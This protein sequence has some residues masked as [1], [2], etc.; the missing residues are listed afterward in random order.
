ML[1]LAAYLEKELQRLDLLL[2]REILRLRARYQLTLD[3]FRGLYVG[4]QQ[5]DSL[6]SE[7]VGEATGAEELTRRADELRTLN[8]RDRPGEWTLLESEF[9]LSNGEQDVILLTIAREANLK[10]ETIFAYLHNDVSRKKPTVELALRLFSSISRNSFLPE[11]PLLE[12]G[13]LIAVGQGGFLGRDLEAT[14]PLLR[15][16]LGMSAESSVPLPLCPPEETLIRSV[17]LARLFVVEHQ[18]LA[19][20]RLAVE[21]S[22]HSAGKRLLAIDPSGGDLPALARRIHLLQRLERCGVCLY[23]TAALWS[24]DPSLPEVRR[25][26]EALAAPSGPIWILSSP[27]S[28]WRGSLPGESVRVISLPQFSQDQRQRTWHAELPGADAAMSKTL[29]SRYS[30]SS[31]QIRA[32][33][34]SARDNVSLKKEDRPPEWDELVA[35][36]QSQSESAIG[37][38]AQRLICRHGWNDLVLPAGTLRQVREVAGAIRCHHVVYANWGFGA[39]HT[40]IDGLK[41]LFAGASG[42]G[43]TMTAGVLGNDLGLDVYRIDLS[44]IVSKYIGET[45]KN[46]DRVFQAAEGS[47]S[48]LFFD[49]ADALFG[50]RSEVKDAHDRYA[51]IEVAYLLQKFEEHD[52]PVILATN[53]RRNLDEAFSRRMH[54]VIEFPQPDEEHR[55]ILWQKIFPRQTPTSGIDFDFLAAQFQITG[56]DI[57]NVA[58]DAAFLAAQ[59]GGVVTMRQIA[60]AMSRQ[61]VK[62][63]RPSAPVDFK[64]YHSLVPRQGT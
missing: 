5:V 57:R 43:K 54:Y 4:D 27:G 58:L 41:I 46:L 7:T 11:A 38:H 8:A 42:T 2:H 25:F 35:A 29:A 59:D 32:A 28:A 39:R 1:P 21:S 12:H 52:G 45:E 17:S 55:L 31:H 6:V 49:E 22:C 30:L 50:K 48:I 60:A 36:I 26:F 33:A 9:G 20:A 15:H 63:G 19:A 23:N 61:M 47:N 3:E 14:L 34:Q 37:R 16:L 18:D 56:G 13:L 51:N 53:L 44:R 64:Q 40:G 24:A 62:Q 10:Y